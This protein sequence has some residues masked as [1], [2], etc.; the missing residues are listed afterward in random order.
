VHFAEATSGGSGSTSQGQDFLREISAHSLAVP[1]GIATGKR[2]VRRSGQ[3]DSVKAPGAGI[4]GTKS[5]QPELASHQR[6][7]EVRL[8]GIDLGCWRTWVEDPQDAEH[9]VVLVGR[10]LDVQQLQGLIAAVTVLGVSG[11]AAEDPLAAVGLP[12]VEL[13]VQA[14]EIA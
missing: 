14:S 2:W 1:G 11:P 10:I 13:P 4:S 9:E 8:R 7:H 3:A 12:D 6:L 5:V